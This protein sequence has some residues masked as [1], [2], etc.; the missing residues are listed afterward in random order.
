MGGMEARR[1]EAGWAAVT[2]QGAMH[3]T[4]APVAAEILQT[5]DSNP[6]SDVYT[7]DETGGQGGADVEPIPDG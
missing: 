2:D 3:A 1:P 7:E 4:S 5:E 6:L